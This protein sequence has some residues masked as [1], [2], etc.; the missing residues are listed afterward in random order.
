MV[1]HKHSNRGQLQEVDLCTVVPVRGSVTPVGANGDEVDTDASC[2]REVPGIRSIE[3]TQ[4]Q[5]YEP[6]YHHYDEGCHIYIIVYFWPQLVLW[7]AVHVLI[8]LISV[9]AAYFLHDMVA[10]QDVEDTW[11]HGY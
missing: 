10:E 2:D 8:F 3:Y 6:D 7:I 1:Q 5:N 4:D 9:E 11:S